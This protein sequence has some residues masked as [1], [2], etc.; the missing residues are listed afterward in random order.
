[1][2]EEHCL[3]HALTRIAER[4]NILHFHAQWIWDEE[5]LC[6]QLAR[7]LFDAGLM[8][9]GITQR[10][11]YTSDLHV[12]PYYRFTLLLRGN[13]MVRFEDREHQLTPGQIACCPP[14]T[15]FK[16][17]N[18]EPNWWIYFDF[19]PRKLWRPLKEHGPYIREHQCP[20]L[21]FIL[22]QQLMDMHSM[23]NEPQ[24][25]GEAHPVDRDAFL[26]E[27]TPMAVEYARMLLNI[28]RQECTVI[29]RRTESQ[30]DQL[31]ALVQQIRL[32]PQLEWNVENMSHHMHLSKS[33][34]RRLMLSE[35]SMSP[36]QL[37]IQA[38]LEEAVRCL[39]RPENTV[40]AVA[41]HVGYKSVYSFTRLF[42][43]HM[44]MSPGKYRD[45]VLRKKK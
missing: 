9:A 45:S 12:P 6:V 17:W 3:P 39:K 40:G 37:V 11:R 28:L 7:P 36:I 8:G 4:P 32:A 30:V 16:R 38:R 20:D 43:K 35:Y 41:N 1:M 14:G 24:L 19:A 21:I 22:L 44:G 15:T 31:H 2:S 5:P 13:M 25:A 26:A 34:L 27:S 23:C 18:E 29:N 42:T 10:N 33:S